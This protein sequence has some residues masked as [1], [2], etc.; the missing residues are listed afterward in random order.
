MTLICVAV[1]SPRTAESNKNYLALELSVSH[2]QPRRIRSITPSNK[3]IHMTA[4]TH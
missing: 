4:M 1:A 3:Y 2:R